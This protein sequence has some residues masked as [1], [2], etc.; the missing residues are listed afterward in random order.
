MSAGTGPTVFPLL[1]AIGRDRLANART[2][3]ARNRDRGA[4]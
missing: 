2:W 3:L 1:M 4:G